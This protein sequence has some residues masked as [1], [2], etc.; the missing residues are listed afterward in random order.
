MPAS[1][2]Q[3]YSEQVVKAFGLHN[4]GELVA[5][6]W[7]LESP[8]GPVCLSAYEGDPMFLD[9]L[10]PRLEDLEGVTTRLSVSRLLRAVSGHY[11][12]TINGQAVILHGFATGPP[13]DV[14]NS[15]ELFSVSA[16]LAQVHQLSLQETVA[17]PADWNEE[18]Q[19]AHH[20]A[21]H[22]TRPKLPRRVQPAW[23]LLWET[24]QLCLDQSQSRWAA[25]GINGRQSLLMG[26]KHFPDF[27][28]VADRHEVHYNSVER[29]TTGPAAVEL[30]TLV[31]ASEYSLHTAESILLSYQRVRSLSNLEKQ[32]LLAC[33]WFPWEVNAQDLMV[34]GL[35]IMAINRMRRLLEQKVAWVTELGEQLLPGLDDDPTGFDTIDTLQT[36]PDAPL[37]ENGD[38]R[39]SIE[40]EGPVVPEKK[41]AEQR[42]IKQ[43]EVEKP[44]PEK[45]QAVVD[46]SAPAI[47]LQSA[48]DKKVLVWKPF[49]RPL[50]APPEEPT[51]E[52]E[53][54]QEAVLPEE[55]DL[56]DETVEEETTPSVDEVADDEDIEP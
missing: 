31:R 53:P 2:L 46:E 5:G 33:L 12:T 7:C 13:C 20:D 1:S 41:A 47:S 34:P 35:S 51:A 38:V 21:Q 37:L 3:A 24:W 26:I 27:I 44:E 40:K 23:E 28:Y 29:C 25:A 8:H 45:V 10:G 30:A 49:P 18:L 4:Q 36:D 15:F 42:L 9:W 17:T 22:L 6:R 39:S 11:Y 54:E 14:H 56:D 52:I 50:G 55:E 16:G 32:Q 43:N 48:T 19:R